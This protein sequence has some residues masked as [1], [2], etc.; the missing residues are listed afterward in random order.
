MW[1]AMSPRW[2]AVTCAGL[3]FTTLAVVRIEAAIAVLALTAW[4]SLGPFLTRTGRFGHT[5]GLYSSELMVLVLMTVW[6]AR[7]VSCMIQ[8]KRMPLQ[9]GPIDR[10]LFCL[11]G[12][13]LFS[14]IA[15]QFTWDYRV[16]T[17]HRY[18]MRQVAEVGLLCMPI[19][20]YL[21][22]SNNLKD[23]RWVRTVFWS[24]LA[25]GAFAFCVMSPWVVIPG[26]F[27]MAWAGLLPVP[28]ISFMYARIVL[29]RQ[30]DSKV[31]ASICVLA[32]LLVVQFMVT[33]WVVMWFSVSVSLCVI[34]W[35]RSKKFFACVLCVVLLICI[36]KHEHFV[37]VIAFERAEQS[38]ERFDLWYAALRMT[39]RRPFWGIGPGNFYPY[40]SYHYAAAYGTINVPSPH[41]NYVQFLVEY[42]IFGV[43]AFIWFV[44]ACLK[45]LKDSLRFAKTDWQK[46][47]FLCVNGHFTGMAV[48][49]LLAD[50]LIP[51]TANDGLLTFGTTLHTWVLLGLAVSLR[52]RLLSERTAKESAPD[53]NVVAKRAT[54]GVQAQSHA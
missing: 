15:A 41:S 46:A 14:L 39:I 27:R 22:V 1:Y 49:A 10:P 36:V 40:Y 33:T 52:G 5:D 38:L 23:E 8:R 32:V 16:P 48:I 13:A 2:A 42:G 53:A 28:L 30:F 26:S 54:A 47:F 29:H 24:V 17:E 11:I 4:M 31:L 20:V 19:A 51:T 25:V 45:F 6:G 34:S 35:H 21:L 50:Y 37:R 44:V 43:A 18:L 3:L 7:L 9:R 12:A